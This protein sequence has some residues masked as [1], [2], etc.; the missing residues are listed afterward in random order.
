MESHTRPHKKRINA[1]GQAFWSVDH[2]A[3]WGHRTAAG[4]RPTETFLGD[5][6]H[7]ATYVPPV[8]GH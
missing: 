5:E 1:D 2:D 8:G 3:R 4:R 7:V 6:A